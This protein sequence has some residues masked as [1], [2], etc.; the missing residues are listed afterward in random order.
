M[1][2]NIPLITLINCK[3]QKHST[4]RSQNKNLRSTQANKEVST[5]QGVE[6]PSDFNLIFFCDM[7]L[8][9]YVFYIL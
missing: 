9:V 2:Q 6:T 1:Q 4:G 7:L 5:T 3:R 8:H